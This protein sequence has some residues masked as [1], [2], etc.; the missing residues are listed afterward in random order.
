[1]FAHEHRNVWGNCTLEHAGSACVLE[2]KPIRA[3]KGRKRLMGL[4]LHIVMHIEGLYRLG[5]WGGAKLPCVSDV[6]GAT[7]EGCVE[8]GERIWGE[9]VPVAPPPLQPLL[10]LPPRLLT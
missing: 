8:G 1:M 3:G 4:P 5:V 9:N 6:Q 7:I 2:D 10:K